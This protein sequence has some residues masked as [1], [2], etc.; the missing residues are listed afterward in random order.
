MTA[1]ESIKYRLALAAGFLKESRQDVELQR[2]RSCVDNAQLA[3]E[4]SGKALLLL[5]GVSPKTH[6]PGRQVADLLEA[7]VPPESLR[8]ALGDLVPDFLALG[9]SQH[10]LTDYGDESTETLPWDLFTRQSAIEALEVAERVYA[11]VGEILDGEL[12]RHRAEGS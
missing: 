3:V 5:F 12:G 6:E 9:F 10:V 11:R 7:G 4:N 1:S 8:P 2:W